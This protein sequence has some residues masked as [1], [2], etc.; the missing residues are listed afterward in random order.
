VASQV[1][2]QEKKKTP[3]GRAKKRITY[4]R[5]FVNVTMTGGKR[6]VSSS[7]FLLITTGGQCLIFCALYWGLVLSMEL[8]GYARM[9]IDG[10]SEAEEYIGDKTMRGC[11]IMRANVLAADEPKPN[12]LVLP[13]SGGWRGWA[14]KSENSVGGD[15][16]CYRGEQEV[17]YWGYCMHVHSIKPSKN[18][19]HLDVPFSSRSFKSLCI[20][21][22]SMSA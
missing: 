4:T 14:Y 1:E 8:V 7:H 12:Y 9:D 2:P 11:R 13:A 16:D 3:K 15:V 5:R 21:Y 22:S 10:G 18:P 20:I 17:K 19:C 6:K